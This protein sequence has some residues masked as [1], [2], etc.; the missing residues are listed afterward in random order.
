VWL[1]S[2]L[3]SAALGLDEEN[4]NSENLGWTICGWIGENFVAVL[5]KFLD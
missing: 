3:R 4:F 2:G 1:F 5:N